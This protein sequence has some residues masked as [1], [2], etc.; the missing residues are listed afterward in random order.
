MDTARKLRKQKGR[1]LAKEEW[2]NT[3]RK[4]HILTNRFCEEG[5]YFFIFL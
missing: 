5:Y 4:G 1:K 3:K 2:E